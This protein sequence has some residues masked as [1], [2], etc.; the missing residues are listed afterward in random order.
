MTPRGLAARPGC[1]C[2]AL[3][4]EIPAVD[5]VT[6]GVCWPRCLAREAKL[7]SSVAIPHCVVGEVDRDGALVSTITLVAGRVAATTVVHIDVGPGLSSCPEA[8]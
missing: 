6:A 1:A 3:E 8:T 4:V 2:V 5:V 7:F